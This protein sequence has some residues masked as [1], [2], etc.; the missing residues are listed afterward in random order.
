MARLWRRYTSDIYKGLHYL[1]T[2]PPSGGVEVGEIAIHQDRALE[3]HS[4]LEKLGVQAETVTG[5]QTEVIGW[6][7]TKATTVRPKAAVGAP[8]EA[9]LSAATELEI[10]F[11]AKHATF[12]RGEAAQHHTLDGLDGVKQEILR[13]H[14]EGEWKR[15]WLLVTQ[16]LKVR[17]LIA[18]ISNGKGAKA[19]L[20]LIGGAVQDPAALATV[21]G[22][23]TVT[24]SSGMAY[25][26]EGVE[27][28]TPLYQ[29]IRVQP[30]L[31]GAD[32]VK[33]VDKRGRARPKEGTFE[34]VNVVF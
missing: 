12:L 8:I 26:E 3:R 18:L 20:T 14:E 34:V 6:V 30:R 25:T 19:G 31:L 10:S 17:R 15:E 28:A 27:T 24:S 33:R 1:A 29:A 32:G 16:V 21:R 22:E 4:T 13:L 23:L 11:N 7:S 2:W 9:G 5:P